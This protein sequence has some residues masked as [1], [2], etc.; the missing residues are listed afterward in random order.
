MLSCTDFIPAYSELFKYIEEKEGYDGVVKYWEHIS[1]TYVADNLGGLVEEKGMLGCWE[2]WSKALNEEA[3]DFGM[4]YDDEAQI[5]TSD[6]RYCPSKGMLMELTYMEPY[7]DYCG[8]CNILYSRVL[9]KYGIVKE[10]DHSE[11]DQAKCKS[12]M[13]FK[14][15][16]N[17]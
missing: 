10:M 2:Y 12:K 1:D 14:N 16:E 8:H 13:Y 9:K 11:C 6:M 4:T 17:T 15:Q 3:A 5:M 7:H